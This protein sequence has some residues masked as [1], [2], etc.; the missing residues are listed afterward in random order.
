[1]HPTRC[2]FRTFHGTQCRLFERHVERCDFTMSS[3]VV[4]DASRPALVSIDALASLDGSALAARREAPRRA[5]S[6]AGLLDAA[7]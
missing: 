7:I 4:R 2:P 5:P 6:M 1:M 3:G